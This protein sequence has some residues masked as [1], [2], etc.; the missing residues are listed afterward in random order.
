M[1]KIESCDISSL[2]DQYIDP[3]LIVMILSVL[4][5]TYIP[6]VTTVLLKVF[7]FEG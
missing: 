4:M 1:S 5:I 2:A 7:G 6:W 3:F